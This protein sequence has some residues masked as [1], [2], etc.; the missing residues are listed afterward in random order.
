MAVFGVIFI[1]PNADAEPV[2]ETK[3]IMPSE[4][5]GITQENS[6]LP[7]SNPSGPN[8]VIRMVVTAYSST[9]EQTDSTPFVTALG[10]TVKDGIVANNLLPF[11]AKI[12]M[13]DLYGDKIFI[14]EDRMNSSKSKYHVDIWLPEYKQALDFGAKTTRVEILED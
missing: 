10:T 3:A 5:M 14:V 13:P 8:R 11:G 1:A 9:V 7:V 12:R 4:T 2:I 6:I